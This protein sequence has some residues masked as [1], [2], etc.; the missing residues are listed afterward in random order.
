MNQALTPLLHAGMV[1]SEPDA[2]DGRARLLKLSP[3]G[4]AAYRQGLETL[5]SFEPLLASR[6]KNPSLQ[7]TLEGLRQVL[8]I[9]REKNDPPAREER[10]RP[11]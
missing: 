8:V 11:R 3:A 2:H 5:S 7:T 6:M 4:V 1:V 10:R 9:L